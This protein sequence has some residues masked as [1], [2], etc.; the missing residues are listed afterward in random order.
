MITQELGQLQIG[1]LTFS[2]PLKARIGGRFLPSYTIDL[3]QI[4]KSGGVLSFIKPHVDILI[5]NNAYRL[6]YGKSGIQT[7]DPNEFNQMTFLDTVSS[8]GIIPTLAIIG[9]LGVLIYLLIR[10]K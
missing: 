6:Q 5:G 10:K 3:S 1:P 2:G 7:I 8:M 9:T 4:P